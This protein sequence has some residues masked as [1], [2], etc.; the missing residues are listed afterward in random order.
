M[1]HDPDTRVVTVDDWSRNL[2]IEVAERDLKWAIAARR[3]AAIAL[4]EA[5]TAVIVAR[6]YLDA[7]KRK[8]EETQSFPPEAFT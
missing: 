1:K 8:R 6:R 7:K 3:K 2:L 4:A 5:E